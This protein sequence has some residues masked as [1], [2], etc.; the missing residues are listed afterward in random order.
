HDYSVAG[1]AWLAT[2]R[3]SSLYIAAAAT[4]NKT[5]KT[6]PAFTWTPPAA[7]FVGD[8]EPLEPGLV[9][10]APGNA[11]DMED[12]D[13]GMLVNVDCPPGVDE[14]GN[15]F[16]A[17]D[18]RVDTDEEWTSEDVVLRTVVSGLEID[19]IE[20]LEVGKVEP[21]ARLVDDSVIVA[22]LKKPVGR[23]ALTRCY[24]DVQSPDGTLCVGYE[25]NSG[26]GDYS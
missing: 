9:E 5:L 20:T 16:G 24:W 19:E 22:I 2:I 23:S 18:C 25:Q 26:K 15:V 8:G 21:G 6:T 17:E 12:E 14:V 13:E 7:A 3:E 10:E 4:P 11:P 1:Q